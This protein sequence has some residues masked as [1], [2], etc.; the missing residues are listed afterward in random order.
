MSEDG[1]HR[2]ASLAVGGATSAVVVTG[3][4]AAVAGADPAGPIIAACAAVLVAL[5]TWFAT[6]RRQRV[7]L[8]A[9]RTRV[10]DRIAEDRQADDRRELR[11][12]LDEAAR[13]YVAAREALMDAS[14]E[15]GPG[16]EPSGDR[17]ATALMLTEALSV[18][19][20]QLRLWIPDDAPVM[21]HLG[22]VEEALRAW[23]ME[24]EERDVDLRVGAHATVADGAFEAFVDAARGEVRA[25][26]PERRS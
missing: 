15:S 8:E 21:R 18:A 13:C 5:I 6:D 22:A 3:L 7:A 12:K 2:D 26:A 23:A 19:K 10:Q 24:L 25:D 17:R 14:A 4:V 16:R 1:P 11:I 9:E 20:Q